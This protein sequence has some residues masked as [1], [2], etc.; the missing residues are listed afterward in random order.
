MHF[1]LIKRNNKQHNNTLYNPHSALG[2][3]MH[4]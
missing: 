3:F 4:E 2:Y 1:Y